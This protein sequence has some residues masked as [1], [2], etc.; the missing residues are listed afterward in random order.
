MDFPDLSQIQTDVD[1]LRAQT[2]SIKIIKNSKGYNYEYKIL[3]ND[4]GEVD[5]IH[6]LIEGVIQKWQATEN[7]K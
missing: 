7:Q 5:R 1:E 6:K 3:S 2:P 4:V